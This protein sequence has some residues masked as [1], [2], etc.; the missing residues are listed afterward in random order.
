MDRT[1]LLSDANAC[2]DMGEDVG[3]LCHVGTEVADMNLTAK[4]RGKGCAVYRS[5]WRKVL[6]ACHHGLFTSIFRK[7]F[8]RKGGERRKRLA[9]LV[10][11]M[12]KW[13]AHVTLIAGLIWLC[14]CLD[15][16]SARTRFHQSYKVAAKPL[17]MANTTVDELRRT[18]ELEPIK[19][20]WHRYKKRLDRL[21]R[22]DIPEEDVMRSSGRIRFVGDRIANLAF[23][24]ILTGDA[25]YLASEK[26]LLSYVIDSH[27]WAKDNDIGAAEVLIG[28]SVAY[29]WLR[30]VLPPDMLLKIKASIAWHAK[31]LD[32]SL[33]EKKIWWSKKYSLLQGHNYVNVSAIAVAGA[34]LIDDTKEA[35]TWVADARKNFLNVLAL[36]PDDG[37]SHEGVAYWSYGLEHIIEF[38]YAVRGIIDIR[39]FV[40]NGYLKNAWY[41]RLHMSSPGF[42]KVANYSDSPDKDYAGPGFLLDAVATIYRNPYAQWL[43]FKLRKARVNEGLSWQDIA[44]FDPS[45]K[46]EDP[47]RNV[48]KNAYF[49]NLGLY[50]DRTSWTK[51]GEWLVYKAGA[52]WGMR[53]QKAGLYPGS[54]IHPD[55]GSFMLWNKGQWVIQDDGYVYEKRTRNHNLLIFNGHGQLGEGKR[56]YNRF[57]LARNRPSVPAPVIVVRNRN[58]VNIRSRL[59]PIYPKS[60]Q[61]SVWERKLTSLGNGA[62]FI[63]DRI[64][65]HKTTLVKG[66]LHL[67]GRPEISRRGDGY[68]IN[69]IFVFFPKSKRTYHKLAPYRLPTRERNLNNKNLGHYEGWKIEYGVTVRGRAKVIV[70]VIPYAYECKEISVMYDM[71][72]HG[73]RLV[74]IHSSIGDWEYFLQ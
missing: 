72:A 28:V 12:L 23:G 74:E 14:G 2:S 1:R 13:V 60:A 71:P 56:W 33:R 68:C 47:L 41:Y 44:W 45:I 54:H 69:G 29:V 51:D 64:E 5:A 46:P 42:E 39:P 43:A 35:Q 52:P 20:R 63:T 67:S 18:L 19:S 34:A 40:D 49:K 11:G 24:Y 26:K 17:F 6:Y 57:A 32:S 58:R 53:A 48:P 38:I 59:D 22:Y 27:R 25:N 15:H 65:T 37:S 8:L 30:S 61:V 50:S 31:I 21:A 10:C 9:A 7:V 66:L 16:T 55:A 62:Y 70:G 36:L 4:H 73:K 3:G